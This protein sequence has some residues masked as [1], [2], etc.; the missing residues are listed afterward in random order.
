MTPKTAK[1][2]PPRDAALL[3]ALLIVLEA[4]A[5]G[6]VNNAQAAR[7]TQTL[8]ATYWE[9]EASVL[10]G[11]IEAIVVGGLDRAFER[12]AGLPHTASQRAPF[13][14]RYI[15]RPDVAHFLARNASR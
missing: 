14:R 11:D 12:A 10:L 5:A 9:R 2:L 13:L 3:D 6:Q 4:H 8:V 1:P 7:L 15:R